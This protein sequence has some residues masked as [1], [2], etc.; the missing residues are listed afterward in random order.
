MAEN[1]IV[2]TIQQKLSEIEQRENVRI[3]YACESGSRAWGFAS[4]DSDY[5]VRFVYV[6][7]KADYLRLEGLRDV[8]E[9][10]LNDVYDI[11]GWDIQ[12]LLRLLMKSN[13]T[14]FEW[15]DSPIVYRETSDWA[16]IRA[17]LSDYFQ[18]DKAMYHYLSMLKNDVRN[19]F[20]SDDI[21]LKKYLY[22][23]RPAL[24]LEWIMSKNS[25]PPIAFSALVGHCLPKELLPSIEKILAAKKGASEKTRGHRAED[26]D[27]FVQTKILASESYLQTYHRENRTT[28]EPL[29]AIFL[30]L[31]GSCTKQ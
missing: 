17:V 26:I 5:D 2:E 31:I 16:K 27:Y 12:K 4:N 21:I 10:E 1:T 15:A 7:N 14:I 8:I 19:Y 11:N 24:A 9:A 6:R 29:N 13:P 20:C 23:L 22:I 18:L 30:D 25:P 28:W 3:L